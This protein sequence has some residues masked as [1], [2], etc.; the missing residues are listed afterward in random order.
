LATGGADPLQ[1]KVCSRIL[2]HRENFVFTFVLK[3]HCFYLT[4]P[5]LATLKDTPLLRDNSLLLA[6]AGISLAR[7]PL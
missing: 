1:M 5:V 6:A 4:R 7:D 3:N 2:Q